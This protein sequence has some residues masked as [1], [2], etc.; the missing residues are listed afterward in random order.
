[1]K[2]Q[3]HN[4]ELC[5]TSQNGHHQKNVQIINAAEGVEKRE[6]SGTVGEDVSWCSHYRKQYGVPQK[7]KNRTTI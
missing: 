6:P 1:M 2:S 4:E 5:L 7:T 3:S